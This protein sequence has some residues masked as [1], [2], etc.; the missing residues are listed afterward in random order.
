MA[1]LIQRSQSSWPLPLA[2]LLA[3]ILTTTAAQTALPSLRIM[4]LGD[5]ITKGNGSPS[6]N[7]YRQFLRDLPLLRA[8]RHRRNNRHD[9]HPRRRQHARQRPPGPWREIP[10][11]CPTV[12]GAVAAREAEYLIW[13]NDARMQANTD[14]FNAKLGGIIDAHGR[15]WIKAPPKV[16]LPGRGLGFRDAITDG[17]SGNCG[18]KNWASKG[19]VF[20]ILADLNGDG[21]TDYIL[22]H[23][24]GSV[25]AWTNTGEA[26]NPWVFLGKINPPW[27]K[28]TREMVRMV[29]VDGDGKA[30]MIVIYEG[31]A[32]KARRGFRIIWHVYDLDGD[33][34]AEYVLIYYEG[35]VKA[36]QK[37]GS[38]NQAGRN[39]SSLG[40][41]APGV[42]GVTGEMIRFADM[43]GDGLADFLAVA[44]DGGIRMWKNKGI[45]GSKGSSLRCRAQAWLNNKNNGWEEYGEIARGL[46]EDLS[47]ARI[48]FVDVN[49]DKRA[50]FLVIYGGGTTPDPVEEADWEKLDCSAPPVKMECGNMVQ[51]NNCYQTLR[52]SDN[53]RG[54]ATFLILNPFA[55][56][57][58]TL[59]NLFD[60]M[61]EA[62]ED[63]SG[64]I[65]RFVSTFSPV[66][67]DNDGLSVLIILDIVALGYGAVMAPFW[68]RWAKDWKFS[69]DHPDGF[70][71]VKDFTNDMT[72]QGITLAKDIIAS[73]DPV[74]TE[75]ALE[76][77]LAR[78]T[79]S[80]KQANRQYAEQLFNGSNPSIDRLWNI[81]DDG[82]VIGPES[83]PPAGTLNPFIIDTGLSCED[84]PK[85]IQH[86]NRLDEDTL[87]NQLIC[88]EKADRGDYLVGAED[89]DND[90]WDNPHSGGYGC[91]H[92]IDLPG[93]DELT[94]KL[95]AVSTSWLVD[96]CLTRTS[97][98]Q[99]T[100]K[101]GT[102]PTSGKTCCAVL[103]SL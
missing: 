57:S 53:D 17:T 41:I 100:P 79:F 61:L 80:W 6:N 60:L 35:A 99:L 2:L 22:A 45:V 78:I 87:K 11:R 102:R 20:T 85:D 44:A 13:A 46:N 26:V 96:L 77:Q 82:K 10:R 32:A 103:L 59:Y 83:P 86:E 16:S 62:A 73:G 47:A 7:G 12:H 29:D 48:E 67:D 70:N 66:M 84:A 94:G 81:I 36:W 64:S 31:G 98:A 95:S 65:G 89:P 50:D 28:V 23:G 91:Q 3:L 63:I 55:Q 68:N 19:Q 58:G 15:G 9:R 39:W 30:D 18:E 97:A 51:N 54:A 40:T 37:T 49:G 43:D 75:N 34:M 92:F 42:E 8:T 5:S 88:D 1:R 33:G 4:P 72:Y 38:L 90:C 56:V 76:E 69:T 25:R 21:Y 93:A 101:S 14:S 74:D 52:C 27:K 71:T 24:D